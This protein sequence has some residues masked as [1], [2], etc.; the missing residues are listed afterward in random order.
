VER[1]GRPRGDPWSL[2]QTGIYHRT[3]LQDDRS[4]YI[5]LQPTECTRRKLDAALRSPDDYAAGIVQTL[6]R[7]HGAILLSMAENWPDYIRDLSAQLDE[8]VCAVPLCE[9]SLV[10]NILLRM[11]RH[12]FHVLRESAKT[13]IR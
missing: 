3:G 1:N 9:I 6:V 2:R 7:T 11:K 10:A 12:V 4:C 13:I 5:L 8:L